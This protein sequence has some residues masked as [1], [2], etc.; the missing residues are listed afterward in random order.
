MKTP[1]A[2]T[3]VSLIR[4][5]DWSLEVVREQLEDLCPAGGMLYRLPDGPGVARFRF[6][7]GDH[8]WTITVP[9]KDMMLSSALQGFIRQVAIQLQ[10]LADKLQDQGDPEGLRMAEAAAQ[11]LS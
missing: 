4:D 10:P 2:L 3:T 7:Y 11:V 6:I 1:R 8:R 5:G 9:N